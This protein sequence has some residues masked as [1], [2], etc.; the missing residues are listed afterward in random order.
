MSVRKAGAPAEQK[1]GK[2]RTAAPVRAARTAVLESEAEARSGK[3]APFTEIAPPAVDSPAWAV[4]PGLWIG[5]NLLV[6]PPSASGLCV[7]RRHKVPARG[8]SG[9]VNPLPGSCTISFEESWMVPGCK[10]IFPRS[11]L[12][13]AGWDPRSMRTAASPES[14]SVRKPGEEQQ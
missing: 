12:A 13:P 11:G 5:P 8:F 9:A 10:L 4:H 2:G 14:S 3:L 6:T 7:E 1:N